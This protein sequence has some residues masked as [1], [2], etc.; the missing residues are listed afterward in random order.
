MFYAYYWPFGVPLLPT[1]TPARCLCLPG[2]ARRRPPRRPGWLLKI[3]LLSTRPPGLM[4]SLKFVFAE[5]QSTG[6]LKMVCRAA[7]GQFSYA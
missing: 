3:A 7:A 2:G 6:L 5:N 4:Y 1:T